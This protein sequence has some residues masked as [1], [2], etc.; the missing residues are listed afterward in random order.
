VNG[1][2]RRDAMDAILKSD[3]MNVD[4][5]SASRVARKRSCDCSSAFHVHSYVSG[6]RLCETLQESHVRACRQA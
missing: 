6:W 1:I 5:D 2:P 3:G 4:D